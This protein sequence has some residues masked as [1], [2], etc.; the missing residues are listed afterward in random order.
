[1]VYSYGP[2]SF[3]CMLI[4]VF[5]TSFV[6]T[7]NV[8]FPLYSL[9]ILAKDQLAIYTRVYFSALY[10]VSLVYISVPILHCLN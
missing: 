8:V 10:F 7:K 9:G 1:M 6:E 5:L 4:P 3:F 2:N